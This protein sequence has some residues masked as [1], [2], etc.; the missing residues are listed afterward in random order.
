MSRPIAN[1]SFFYYFGDSRTSGKTAR[2]PGAKAHGYG[3]LAGSADHLSV[4]IAQLREKHEWKTN[5]SALVC[6]LPR[7]QS[8]ASENRSLSIFTRRQQS[9][10]LYRFIANLTIMYTCIFYLQ[11]FFF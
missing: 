1:Q 10:A 7:L 9:R 3:A 5:V 6:S 2:T 8:V 11:F 4:V